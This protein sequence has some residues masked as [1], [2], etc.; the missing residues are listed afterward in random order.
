MNVKSEV[1]ARI[2]VAIALL[3][4]WSLYDSVIIKILVVIV[5]VILAGS[6]IVIPLRERLLKS[7]RWK[8]LGEASEYELTFLALG[9]AM[10]GLAYSLSGRVSGWVIIGNIIT[11][12]FFIGAGIGEN[13]RKMIPRKER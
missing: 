10:F 4:F 3:S 12:A 13:I 9:L 5:I 7:R 1:A 8:R 6:C 2:G 11:G